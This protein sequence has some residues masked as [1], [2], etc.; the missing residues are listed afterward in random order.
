MT[1]RIDAAR[2]DELRKLAASRGT[3]VSALVRD[4]LLAVL[5]RCPTCAARFES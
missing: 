1:V 2:A 3:T 4:A 5:E